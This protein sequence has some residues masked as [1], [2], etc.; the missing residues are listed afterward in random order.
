MLMAVEE[1]ELGNPK[2]LLPAPT[3]QNF[4]TMGPKNY[5]RVLNGLFSTSPD[6]SPN[7]T[8]ANSKKINSVNET[9]A[10]DETKEPPAIA[11]RL[12]ESDSTA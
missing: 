10:H 2:W 6:P 5:D 4:K 1:T 12:P 7:S 3:E 11:N 9:S 8:L